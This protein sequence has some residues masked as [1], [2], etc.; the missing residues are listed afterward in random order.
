M[1]KI[2]PIII[3]ILLIGSGP[4]AVATPTEK[5][6]A[7]SVSFS[8]FSVQ[9]SNDSLMINVEGANSVFMRPGFYMVPTRIETL[10]F[11]FGTRIKSVVC[12]PENIH[13]QSLTKELMR[14]P[15]PVPIDDT[16]SQ[17]NNQ[18]NGNPTA[19]NIWYDYDVGTG[20]IRDNERGVILKVQLFPVQYHPSEKQVEWSDSFDVLITY[21]ESRQSNECNEDY[22]LLVLTPTEFRNELRPLIEHKNSRVFS[23]KMVTLDEI[24]NGTY[25]PAAGRDNQ[26]EIKYFIKRAVEQWG[27][28]YVLLVGG[29]TKFPTR[30]SHVYYPSD[31]GIFISDLYYADIYDEQGNFSSWDTNG[32]NIF[33]EYE[34]G[35][36]PLTDQIDLYPDVY[37]GRLACTNTNEVTTC[38]N[39]IITYETNEAYAQDWFTNFTTIG[40]DTFPG[41][42]K[43]IDEGEYT[44]Q[45][46]INIMSGFTPK[47]LWAS[48]GNLTSYDP[49]GA[50]KINDVI[51]EGTGFVLFSGHGNEY[52]FATH[53]HNSNRWIPYPGS[54]GNWYVNALTN[55]NKL[56]IVFLSACSCG[57]YDTTPNC[58]SW[59]FLSNPNGGGIGSFGATALAWGYLGS[60]TTMGLA[61]GLALNMFQAYHNETAITFGEIWGKMISLYIYADMFSL[62]YKTIEEWQPFGDPSLIIREKSSQPPEKP[63]TPNGTTSGI[64]NQQYMYQTSTTDPDEDDVSYLVDWGDG[65]ILGIGPYTSGQ[66]VNIKHRWTNK[67]GFQIKV[68]AKDEHGVFSPWSDSLT[69]HIASPVLD[70][71]IKGGFGIKLKIKNTGDL[72]ATNVNYSITVQGGVMSR[73]NI[74]KRG[75]LS[76]ISTDEETTI[77]PGLF[78]GF[79]YIEIKATMTCD[80]G[81]SSLPVNAEGVQ[82]FFFTLKKPSH[83]SSLL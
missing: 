43:N 33:G 69:V 63:A 34:W 64:I 68:R 14:T 32:N 82:L 31:D 52:S 36:P 65:E 5:T 39:K 55:E 72:A 62:D 67:G 71:T 11:P 60:W 29:S 21:K 42:N 28:S 8:H 70:V 66:K 78:V 40:G 19:V 18:Q 17:K 35:D 27:T 38:V 77:G 30:L 74:S 24:Y 47:N 26:E 2:I 59:S 51:N 3:L 49:S 41:D 81:V 79:G 22:R 23:T 83:S 57:R 20:L 7:F 10:T 45:A 53:P 76:S 4:W 73:I 80:E 44:C 54:Y 1:K 13:R 25:F 48:N 6:K 15:Y 58:F 16:V 75:V 56:S 37:L 12:T 50:Q 9:E 46:A 61:N